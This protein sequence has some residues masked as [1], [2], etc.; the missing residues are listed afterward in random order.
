MH[1]II[2]IS[3]SIKH[4]FRISLL[5]F[6]FTVACLHS[7]GNESE[8]REKLH[9]MGITIRE[10]I[11]QPECSDA[12]QCRS[13]PFGSKPCGGPW[14]YLVY[15]TTQTDSILLAEYV[16][17]YNRFEDE[18]NKKYGYMSDCMVILPPTSLECSKGL[19][20]ASD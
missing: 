3:H 6:L 13:I 10:L 4:M 19:C 8:D 7:P 5:F 9:Q 12:A 16:M 18:M 15:S 11:G 2:H 20:A 14:E 17:E 1:L